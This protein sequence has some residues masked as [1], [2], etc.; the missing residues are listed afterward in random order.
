MLGARG[1]LGS[2]AA[3]QNQ[4]GQVTP[5]ESDIHEHDSDLADRT[6]MGF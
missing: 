3:T 6:G 2:A 5:G 1:A 4:L